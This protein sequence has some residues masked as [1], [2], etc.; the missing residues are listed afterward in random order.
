MGR[1]RGSKNRETPR[2]KSNANK[3][4]YNNNRERI[5]AR[6]KDNKL[7]LKINRAIKAHR[8]KSY[9]KIKNILSISSVN[10]LRTKIPLYNNFSPMGSEKDSSG[11]KWTPDQPETFATFM[12]QLSIN[13]INN[14]FSTFYPT[15]AKCLGYD[16]ATVAYIKLIMHS[17]KLQVTLL[18]TSSV[19]ILN[20]LFLSYPIKFTDQT[21]LP[22][23]CKCELYHH[24]GKRNNSW[25]WQWIYCL[26]R[27]FQNKFHL[28]S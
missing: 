19:Y 5:L 17:F 18:H 7:K 1:T 14:P 16:N 24:G 4:Y 12:N 6:N 27:T 26:Y 28:D 9:I 22:H 8:Y 20:L 15:V 11:R 10:L 3:K 23:R 25:I 21:K 2:G 13:R